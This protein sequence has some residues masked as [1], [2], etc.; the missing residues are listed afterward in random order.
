M[1]EFMRVELPDILLLKSDLDSIVLIPLQLEL[2]NLVFSLTSLIPS[3]LFIKMCRKPQAIRL[4]LQLKR[5][6]F[7]ETLTRIQLLII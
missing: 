6:A 3:L 1:T 4:L 7:L 5:N 2:V